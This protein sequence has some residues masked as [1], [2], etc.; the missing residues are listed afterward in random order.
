MFYD[1]IYHSD[2][3]RKLINEVRQVVLLNQHADGYIWTLLKLV[4]EADCYMA[5]K[6]PVLSRYFSPEELPAAIQT[7][8]TLVT[9]NMQDECNTDTASAQSFELEIVG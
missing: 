3:Q 4:Y 1:F 5:K 6:A 2:P 7:V 8:K 9:V